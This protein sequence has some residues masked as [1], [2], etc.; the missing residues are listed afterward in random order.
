[1]HTARRVTLWTGLVLALGVS[2]A[3]G[4]VHANDPAECGRLFD[5]F[6]KVVVSSANAKT[7]RVEYCPDETCEVFA[8]PRLASGVCDFVFLYLFHVSGYIYL[9]DARKLPEVRARGQEILARHS[10]G[11]KPVGEREAVESVLK[12]LAQRLSISLT[13]VRYDEGRRTEEPVLLKD[14]L[15]R[16]RKAH[17]GTS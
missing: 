12:T 15:A 1:M 5:A 3:P 4:G 10:K 13:F 7:K 6:G 9:E 17:A 2:P 16:W 11:L 8:A 14:E